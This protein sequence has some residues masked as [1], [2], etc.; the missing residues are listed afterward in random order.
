MKVTVVT[1]SLNGM[2]YLDECIESVKIQRSENIDVE[3]MSS[4]EAAPTGRSSSPGGG[5]APS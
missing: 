4:T 3:H 1:L 2:R 5:A